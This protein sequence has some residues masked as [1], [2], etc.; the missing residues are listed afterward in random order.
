MMTEEEFATLKAELFE[1][2][3]STKSEKVKMRAAELLLT[4]QDRYEAARWTGF[5]PGSK[6]G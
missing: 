4:A 3:K 2:L 6:R 1:I 5:A